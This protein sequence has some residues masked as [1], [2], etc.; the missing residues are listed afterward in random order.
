LRS[1]PIPGVRPEALT[2][3][4]DD[5]GIDLGRRGETLSPAE[6]ARF[7]DAIKTGKKD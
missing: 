1:N 5:A 7:T 2:Q 4:A 3:A 6:F